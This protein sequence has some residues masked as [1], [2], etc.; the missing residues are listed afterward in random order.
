MSIA[1]PFA[2]TLQLYFFQPICQVSSPLSVK[3]NPGLLDTV[4]LPNSISYAYFRVTSLPSIAKQGDLVLGIQFPEQNKARHR[5]R[6]RLRALKKHSTWPSVLA[7]FFLSWS[8]HIAH[9]T[10]NGG[11]LINKETF[12][13]SLRCYSFSFL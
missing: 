3:N 10:N 5:Q 13:R 1:E 2:G 6:P 11:S 7:F 9:T 12:R 4:S 8:M